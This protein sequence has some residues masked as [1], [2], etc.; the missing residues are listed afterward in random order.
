MEPRT[1]S[2]TLFERLCTRTRKGDIHHFDECPP[3][4]PG[5]RY[6]HRHSRNASTC[7]SAASASGP[8]PRIKSYCVQT[9]QVRGQVR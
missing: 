7:L 4:R 2:E 5:H 3:C 9:R 8:T 6:S 1:Y